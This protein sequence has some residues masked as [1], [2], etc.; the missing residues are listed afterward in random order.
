[1]QVLE[2]LLKK[3]YSLPFSSWIKYNTPIHALNKKTHEMLWH[4]RLIHM[5]PQTIQNT[6]KF[7][8]GDP[9]LSKLSFD[10][11]NQCPTC[12]GANFCNNALGNKVFLSPYRV[13]TKVSLLI[14]RTQVDFLTTRKTKWSK[15]PPVQYLKS[16]LEEY[17]RSI[18]NKFVVLDQGDEFWGCPQ[19]TKAI[20]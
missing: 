5:S 8:N 14:W 18:S 16:F 15:T 13:H 9:D 4:K 17:S 11:I 12:I 19:D 3:Y 20:L 2:S 7:V 6:H 1:M 10:N